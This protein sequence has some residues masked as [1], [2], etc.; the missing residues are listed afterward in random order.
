MEKQ[1]KKKG[2]G[3]GGLIASLILSGFYSFIVVHFI[4][5]KQLN[6]FASGS[7]ANLVS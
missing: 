5:V 4:E 3:I 2:K 1:E 6:F 7:K